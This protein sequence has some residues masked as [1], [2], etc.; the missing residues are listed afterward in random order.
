MEK[1]SLAQ[2]E[3]PFRGQWTC[4]IAF[5]SD[6]YLQQQEACSI[7]RD[8]NVGIVIKVFC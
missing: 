6:C 3:K 2:T 5:S 1:A 4:H 8:S 7:S